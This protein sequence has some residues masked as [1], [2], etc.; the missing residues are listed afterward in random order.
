MK[1]LNVFIS[2]EAHKIIQQ[3]QDEKG[4]NTR[5]DAANLYILETAKL[6]AGSKHVD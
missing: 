4:L 1:R 2:D 6:R 5:D 3:Y